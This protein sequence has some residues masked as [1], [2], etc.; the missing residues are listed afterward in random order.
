VKDERGERNKNLLDAATF[1]LTPKKKR[2]RKKKSGE[3]Q[4]NAKIADYLTHPSKP[5]L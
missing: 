2:K 3:L 5:S 1:F 4:N